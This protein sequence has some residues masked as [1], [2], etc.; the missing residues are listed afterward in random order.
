MKKEKCLPIKYRKFALFSTRS[1]CKL[2]NMWINA[3]NLKKNWIFDWL[4]AL[5]Y[6]SFGIQIQNTFAGSLQRIT[7]FNATGLVCF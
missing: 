6:E 1:K 3:I 7:Y 5:A 4:S 2:M